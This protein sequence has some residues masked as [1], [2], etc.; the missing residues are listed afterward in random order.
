MSRTNAA[1]QS[2]AAPAPSLAL[3]DGIRL[4]FAALIAF[5]LLGVTAGAVLV[6]RREDRAT[7][8]PDAP[9]A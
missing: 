7:A 8:A 6:V 1:L 9:A 4:A 2:P 3:T 5:A